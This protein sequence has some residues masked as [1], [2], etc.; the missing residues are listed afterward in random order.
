MTN[1][2]LE[3]GFLLYA[4]QGGALEAPASTLFAIEQAIA[5]GANAIELDVHCSKDG[6]LLV[7]HDPIVDTTSDG[8]G[9]IADLDYGYISQLDNAYY[10]IP[11]KGAVKPADDADPKEVYPY[12]GRACDDFKFRFAR[13]EEVL[14]SFPDPVYNFD[15]KETAPSVEPYEALLATVLRQYQRSD[16]VI[17]ASFHDKAIETFSVAAP[18]FATAPGAEE[19]TAFGQAFFTKKSLPDSIRRHAALQI[20][21]KLRNFKIVTPEFVHTAHELGLAVHVWTVNDTEEASELLDAKVDGI[22]T[23]RPK[24]LANQP[25]VRSLL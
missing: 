3:R 15:I 8:K 12:R 13:L 18:E 16:N 22:M 14:S 24:L 2:W 17:V 5:N 20:P 10:F 4:H 19:T 23:D 11:D 6:V 9:A 25:T 1:T 21:F 7:G